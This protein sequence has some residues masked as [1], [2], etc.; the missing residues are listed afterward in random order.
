MQPKVG[1]LQG[2]SSP[3]T[4]AWSEIV[5]AAQAVAMAFGEPMPR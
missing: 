3:G 4:T 5:K 1:A 2:F